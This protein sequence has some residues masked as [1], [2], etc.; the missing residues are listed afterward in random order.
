MPLHID[1]SWEY[2]TPDP[3]VAELGLEG[4]E[5][6]LFDGR[7]AR[8][9]GKAHAGFSFTPR[10]DCYSSY[11]A[12]EKVRRR[13]TPEL[14]RVE[15]PTCKQDFQPERA[16]RRYC[17]VGCS[18]RRGGAASTPAARRQPRRK[19]P[20]SAACERCGAPFR[21]YYTGQRMCSRRCASYLGAPPG[22]DAAKLEGFRAAYL[23]GGKVKDIA[24]AVGVTLATAKRW[25]RKLGLPARPVGAPRRQAN[26]VEGKE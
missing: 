14:A 2:Y 11:V 26:P 19:L 21:P 15:C 5:A 24:D 25:R 20:E 4:A 10:P 16:S 6:E 18:A 8:S 7:R 3:E 23:R 9:G 17:S 12:R 13:E 1:E 22:P